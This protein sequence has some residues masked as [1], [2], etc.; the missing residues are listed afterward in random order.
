MIPYTKSA[1]F[2][3]PV[4]LLELELLDEL[5][6]ELLDELELA[7]PLDEEDELLDDEELVAWPEDEPSPLHAV[8]T[9]GVS[10]SIA[11]LLTISLSILIYPHCFELF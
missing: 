5:E 7:A 2:K 1:E 10:A 6:L 8:S 11:N 9:N 3:L 4:L